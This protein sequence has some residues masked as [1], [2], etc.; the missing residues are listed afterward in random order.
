MR[1]AVILH[2]HVCCRMLSPVA[3][4]TCGPHACPGLVQAG[5]GTRLGAHRPPPHP[6]EKLRASDV[7]KCCRCPSCLLF[8]LGRLGDSHGSTQCRN[9]RVH[10]IQSSPQ[11]RAKWVPGSFGRDNER[12][13][14]RRDGRSLRGCFGG[15]EGDP[16]P[17]RRPYLSLP[18]MLLW[19][20]TRL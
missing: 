15:E 2:Q 8:P 20:L 5:L 1:S 3:G 17:F 16:S 7:P 6:P 13:E 12:A 4:H 9:K 19:A 18:Y 10:L 14:R 11:G